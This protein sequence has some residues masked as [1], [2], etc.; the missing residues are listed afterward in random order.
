MSAV[1][2]NTYI[3]VLVCLLCALCA[4]GKDDACNSANSNASYIKENIKL[5]ME[6]ESLKMAKYFGY[7]ALNGIVKTASNFK[8]CGCPD[9]TT[10]INSARKV[11]ESALKAENL[12]DSKK[13]LKG[14]HNHMESTIAALY[15]FERGFLQDYDA[16]LKQQTQVDSTYVGFEDTA[17]EKMKNTVDAGL[18]RF[19]ASLD[20]VVAV[21]DCP[22]ALQYVSE[23]LEKS[24]TFLKSSKL[25]PAQA[26]Y[27]RGVAELANNAFTALQQCAN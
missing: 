27:H 12:E 11:L 21:V 13:L 26:H 8:D 20:H 10:H 6:V 1:V 4:F 18:K 23:V 19:G 14:A 25:T 9:A 2:K 24:K 16:I 5:A 17:S 7:R 15:S 22:K 3:S